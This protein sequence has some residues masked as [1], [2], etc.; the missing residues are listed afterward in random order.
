[1]LVGD[2]KKHNHASNRQTTQEINSRKNTD[3]TGSSLQ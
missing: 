3:Q 2:V 1:M